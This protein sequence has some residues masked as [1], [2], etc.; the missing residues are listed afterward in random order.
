MQS[1]WLNLS[2]N[3][4]DSC[5]NACTFAKHGKLLAEWGKKKVKNQKLFVIQNRERPTS[6]HH[7]D[8]NHDLGFVLACLHESL[9]AQVLEISKRWRM[10]SVHQLCRS[11]EF[12]HTKFV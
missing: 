7:F 9:D 11:I 10:H 2:A 5:A 3:R 6:L 1:L 4:A 12:S 8:Q